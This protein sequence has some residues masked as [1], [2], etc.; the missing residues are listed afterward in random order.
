MERDKRDLC[1]VTNEKLKDPLFND[2]VKKMSVMALSTS[3]SS[4]FTYVY[5]GYRMVSTLDRARGIRINFYIV[6]CVEKCFRYS[7]CLQI[8]ITSS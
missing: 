2:R 8:R 7:S 6:I 3:Y 5:G 1:I 4:C